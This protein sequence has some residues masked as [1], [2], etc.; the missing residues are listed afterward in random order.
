MWPRWCFLYTYSSL[1]KLIQSLSVKLYIKWIRLMFELP[2]SSQASIF[3]GISCYGSF[4][5]IG[6]IIVFYFLF[7]TGW[8]LV[9]WLCSRLRRSCNQ[10]EK[11]QVWN[12]VFLCSIG[13]VAMADLK[14]WFYTH[15]AV[16]VFWSL[17]NQW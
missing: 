4:S 7:A 14:L 8:N 16:K 15:M 5:D 2:S 11:L 13:S 1:M 6:W 12:K 10:S 3:I 9:G 17:A